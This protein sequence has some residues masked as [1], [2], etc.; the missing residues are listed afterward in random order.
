MEDVKKGLPQ[1]V[2]VVVSFDSSKF[3][4]E[5]IAD[6]GYDVFLGGLLAAGIMFIFLLSI[7][8]TLI[9]AIAIRLP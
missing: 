2:E 6:V 1:G 5:A 9:T 7:R 3:I 4:E 8:S